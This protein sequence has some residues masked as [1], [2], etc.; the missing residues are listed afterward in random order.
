MAAAWLEL[1]GVAVELEFDFVAEGV[2]GLGTGFEEL[3]VALPV[4]VDLTPVVVDLTPDVVAFVVFCSLLPFVVWP[5]LLVSAVPL[6]V[7]HRLELEMQV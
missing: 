5:L 2:Q 6:V 1:V 7:A 4:V 3:V